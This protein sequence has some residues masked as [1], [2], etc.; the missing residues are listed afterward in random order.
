MFPSVYLQQMVKAITSL[1]QTIP[2][3]QR[4]RCLLEMEKELLN[5][6]S[7]LY[8]TGHN[9]LGN[10]FSLARQCLRMIHYHMLSATDPKC[11][12]NKVRSI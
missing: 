3:D 12:N 10:E 6:I 4:F 1:D 11:A 8:F 7:N 2:W 9:Y 5:Y